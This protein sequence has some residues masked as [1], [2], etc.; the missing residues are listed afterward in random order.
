ML[1]IQQISQRFLV[2][3][4]RGYQILFSPLLGPKC[5]FYPSCSEYAKE[6]IS[7]HGAAKGSW[8]SA[9]RICKCHPLHQGG[10]DPVPTKSELLE[11][12]LNK[13]YQ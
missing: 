1:N 12:K 5:R 8:M 4:I 10:Y 11:E 7:V 2:S 3:I 6:A 13:T 9:K